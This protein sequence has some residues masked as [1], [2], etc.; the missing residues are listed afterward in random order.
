MK[1]NNSVLIT[2]V[3]GFIGY[4]VAEAFLKYSYFDKIVGIDNLNN[5]YD[6]KLKKSRINNLLK[7]YKNN[8][9][10]FQKINISNLKKLEDVIEEYQITHIIHLAAQA[11]VRYSIFNPKVYFKSNILGFQNI[12]D[13]SIKFNIKHLVYA[14]SSSVYGESNKTPFKEHSD[15]NRPLSFYAATKKANEILAH[16]YSAIYN[17]PCTGLR[18]F[19]V[20]GK[21]GRP[22]MSYYKFVEKILNNKKINLYNF[23]NHTRDFTHVDDVVRVIKSLIKKPSKDK[24]PFNIF[25]LGSSIKIKLKYLIFLIEKIIGK[26]ANIELIEKQPGDIKDTLSSTKKLRAKINYK[27]AMKFEK[28]MKEF[29]D[30]YVNYHN[31]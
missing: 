29:I 18:F 14:S 28:G 30:W 7:N 6:T 9:F 1:K 13:A 20:Y 25:N 8:K 22:D 23:G 21:Y 4:H 3:A 26:K 17:L 16:S 27:P 5:Y 11:G 12:L 15:T 10:I 31:K 2:G 24:I 19:T